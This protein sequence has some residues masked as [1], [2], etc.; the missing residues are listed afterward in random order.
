MMCAWRRSGLYTGRVNLASS[1]IRLEKTRPPDNRYITTVCWTL[2]GVACSPSLSSPRHQQVMLNRS[3]PS[4]SHT[5]CR[6]THQ[7]AEPSPP[8]RASGRPRAYWGY[9]VHSVWNAHPSVFLP[10]PVKIIVPT[11]SDTCLLAAARLAHTP[12]GFYTVYKRL[13]GK[14]RVRSLTI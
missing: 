8:R 1:F 3:A 9:W 2:F 14:G 7:R 12:P 11:H 10:D 13:S 5:R 6:Q 4:S